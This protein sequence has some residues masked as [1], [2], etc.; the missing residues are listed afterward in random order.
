[1]ARAGR[2]FFRA[3]KIYTNQ[4]WMTSFGVIADRAFLL[5]QAETFLFE[6]ADQLA[7]LH[8]LRL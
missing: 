4:V 8:R 3:M 2:D 7:E 6:Q 1:M 5:Y